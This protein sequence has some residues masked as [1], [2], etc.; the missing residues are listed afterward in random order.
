VL[1][2]Q[3][4]PAR[5]DLIGCLFFPPEADAAARCLAIVVGSKGG[6]AVVHLRLSIEEGIYCTAEV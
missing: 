4:Q 6:F 3:R 5:I 1:Q 2:T